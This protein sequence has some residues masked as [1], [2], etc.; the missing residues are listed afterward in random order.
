MTAKRTPPPDQEPQL[1][2]PHA[3]KLD[4][5]AYGKEVEDYTSGVASPPAE[6]V[7]REVD[8]K[9]TRSVH[10]RRGKVKGDRLP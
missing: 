5:Q 7:E 8:R 6:Q 1:G 4:G 2:L 10:H 9:S 3:P